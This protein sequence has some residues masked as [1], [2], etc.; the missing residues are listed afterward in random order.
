MTKQKKVQKM[1]FIEENQKIVQKYKMLNL[2][3]WGKFSSRKYKKN[4]QVTISHITKK[5]K[6]K[7]W[8]TSSVGKIMEQWNFYPITGEKAFWYGHLGIVLGSEW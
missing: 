6:I 5:Q 2:F 8:T 7:K 4:P 3:G 1:Y